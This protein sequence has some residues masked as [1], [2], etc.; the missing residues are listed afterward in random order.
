[1][2]LHGGPKVGSEVRFISPFG[3]A[4]RSPA[5]FGLHSDHPKFV[6]I[7]DTQENCTS[8]T[9]RRIELNRRIDAAKSFMMTEISNNEFSSVYFVGEHQLQELFHKNSAHGR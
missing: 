8:K 1:V 6:T 2:K 5:G 3:S 4:V 9:L 7:F